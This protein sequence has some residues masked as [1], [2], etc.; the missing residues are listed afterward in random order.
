MAGGLGER[1]GLGGLGRLGANDLSGDRRF[2]RKP[3]SPSLQK[4]GVAVDSSGSLDTSDH[5][6]LLL[7]GSTGE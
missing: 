5:M 4:L 6:A 1:V 3:P 7:R 2:I